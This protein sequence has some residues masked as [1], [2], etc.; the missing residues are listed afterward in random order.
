MIIGRNP[1]GESDQITK[2]VDKLLEDLVI[3]KSRVWM[4][5]A[6]KCKSP[7]DRPPT[8]GELQACKGILQAE[9]RLVEPRLVIC[10]GTEAMTMVTDYKSGASEHSG[11]I[12]DKVD[13]YVAILTHPLTA[14]RSKP[15]RIDYD[16]G[17][18]K[19]KEFLTEKRKG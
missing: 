5:N 16:Y 4:T 8:Y 7:G 19:L 17:V 14:L 12:L 6:C 15:R 13:H 2:E 1:H 10:L 3:D 11:E 9:L 18:G